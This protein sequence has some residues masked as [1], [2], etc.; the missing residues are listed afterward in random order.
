MAWLL[1]FAARL[2]NEKDMCTSKRNKARM[3]KE[4]TK[5]EAICIVSLW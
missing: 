5:D 1:C 3:V 4:E 2:L